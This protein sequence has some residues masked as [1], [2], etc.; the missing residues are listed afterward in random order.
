MHRF[1]K[2]PEDDLCEEK[3]RRAL[4]KIGSPLRKEPTIKELTGERASNSIGLFLGDILTLRTE[5]V[6]V[7]EDFAAKD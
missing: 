6:E 2:I 3:T 5:R 1:Q 4:P 7:I